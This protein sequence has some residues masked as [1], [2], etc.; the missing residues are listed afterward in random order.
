MSLNLDLRAAEAKVARATEH[1]RTL[2]REMLADV[3]KTDPYHSE[4]T[5][6]DPQTGWCEV[7]LVPNGDVEKPRLGVM[8]GDI[9]HNLRCAL[10]YIVTELVKV[11]NA[12]LSTKHQFPIYRDEQ[13]YKTNVGEIGA[14][15][16]TGPLR[17]IKYGDGLIES[18]Q[19]YKLHP[20]PRHDPL[21]VVH[22]F[23]N[24]DKHRQVAAAHLPPQPGQL[25]IHF[26][27]TLVDKIDGADNPTWKPKDKIL[28]ASLRFDPPI[29]TNLRT[30][31]QVTVRVGFYTETF[32][33]EPE[34][35]IDL[36]VLGDACDHLSMVI[37]QF[38][39]L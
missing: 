9:M 13:V 20:E 33:A 35:R 1:Y 34:Q 17:F 11:S 32:G 21:W 28:M 2:E 36:G 16:A 12:A 10:D 24:A 23:S 25:Q 4:F 19:P 30:E 37:E 31:G 26:N 7:W 18:L 8:L 39:T 15:L 3:T 29:A 27:G 14:P 22:R 5:N 6:V 38:K